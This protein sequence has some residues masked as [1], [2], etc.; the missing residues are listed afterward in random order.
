MEK[1]AI[2][3]NYYQAG[4][5]SRAL[6]MDVR[7]HLSRYDKTNLKINFSISYPFV[8]TSIKSALMKSIL[9]VSDL[10]YK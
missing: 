5:L 2:P 4:P 10:F 9:S 1:Y 6:M 7:S 8:T 3:Q